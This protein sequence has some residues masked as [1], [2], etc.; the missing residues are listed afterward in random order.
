MSWR[1]LLQVQ[2]EAAQFM[3]E[4]AAIRPIACPNDGVPLRL[5]T[6]GVLFCPFDGW[7]A[8]A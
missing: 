5:G 7:R 8:D 3:A 6:N 1:Q 4:D 2:A